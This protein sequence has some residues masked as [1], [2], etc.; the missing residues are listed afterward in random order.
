MKH[1]RKQLQPCHL[2]FGSDTHDLCYGDGSGFGD[3]VI[4]EAASGQSGEKG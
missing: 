4:D 2:I 3:P 1:Y